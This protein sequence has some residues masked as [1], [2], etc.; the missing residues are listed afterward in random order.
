MSDRDR[1][2]TITLR[3][4]GDWAHPLELMERLPTGVRLTAESLTLPDGTSVEFTP[5]PPDDEFPQVFQTACRRPPRRGEVAMVERYT[6]NVAL[7]GPGGSL[8]SALAMIE[9]GAAIVGAGGA[10]VFIDNSALAHGGE[11]WLEIADDGGPDAIS[12]AFTSIVRS[13]QEIYT[14]GMH[15]MGFPDLTMP[16]ADVREDGDTIV[17]L[18]RYICGGGRPI[19]VGDI[20]LLVDEGG[21]FQVVGKD[22]DGH[23]AESPMHNPWG[24]LKIVSLRGIGEAN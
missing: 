4:P 8:E 22:T 21:K 18:I 11:D 10:G 16:T 3:I 20:I 9:A 15:T 14:H 13:R 17:D 6:V 2:T 7:S 23:H 24:R 12:F 1:G 19:E 5:M